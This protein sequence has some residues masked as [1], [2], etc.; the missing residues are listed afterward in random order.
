MGNLTQIGRI[1]LALY[2]AYAAKNCSELSN[3]IKEFLWAVSLTIFTAVFIA[4]V[5]NL[6]SAVITVLR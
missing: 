3:G 1:L 5:V 4:A 2:M 6:A